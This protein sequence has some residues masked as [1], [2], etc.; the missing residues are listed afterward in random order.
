MQIRKLIVSSFK[1]RRSDTIHARIQEFSSGGGEGGVQVH[2]GYKK[3]LTKFFL[4]NCFSPQFILQKSS[5]YFQRKLLFAKVPVGWNIFQG[6][7]TFYRGS[8][9][10]SL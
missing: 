3:A 4:F 7:P 2:L 1:R 6:G 10:F 5:G 9:A 8:I